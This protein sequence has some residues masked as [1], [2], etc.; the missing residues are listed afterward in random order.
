M[1]PA[2]GFATYGEMRRAVAARSAWRA[3]G[4]AEWPT[5]SKK[6]SGFLLVVAWREAKGARELAVSQID[7]KGSYREFYKDTVVFRACCFSGSPE[8]RCVCV[9]RVFVFEGILGYF[10]LA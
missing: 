9:W 4:A 7:N 6:S 1:A 10:R 8:T 5:F 3:E 2:T